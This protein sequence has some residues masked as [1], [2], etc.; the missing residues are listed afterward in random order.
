MATKKE[1][2]ELR[3]EF[4]LARSEIESLKKDVVS[5]ESSRKWAEDRATKAESELEQVHAFF[6]AIPNSLPRKGDNYE[7]R[8]LMTR[9]AA[10]I[11]LREIT[12]R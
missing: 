5:K 10:W 3:T 1:H 9:F 11:A 12:S 7:Q 6:D 4:N 8:S 2:D